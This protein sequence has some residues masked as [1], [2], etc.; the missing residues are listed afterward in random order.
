ML[1]QGELTFSA[2]GSAPCVV[3][4]H[5]FGG[6]AAELRPLLDRIASA[7]YAV[8]AALLPGHGTDPADLQ[9]VRW[10]DWVGAARDRARAAAGRYGRFFLLGFSLGSLVA[11]HLA[12]EAPS[13]GLAGLVALGTAVRLER[14]TQLGLR[15]FARLGHRMPDLYVRKPRP[16][17]LVDQSALSS[18]ATYDR[19]PLRAAT[20][21]VAMGS[22]VS[23]EVGRVTCPTLILHGRKDR[24][25][26]WQNAV[27]LADHVGSKD[28]SVRIFERSAHVLACD[29]EREEVAQ[30]VLAFLERLR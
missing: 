13:E 19:N 27:W 2:E 7:G 8:D 20:Q 9:R 24:V 11:L 26:P 21:V 17:D 4:F 12:S 16:G 14:F 6:S 25:C 10:E 23:G 1:G 3:A 30:E 15:A 29:F 18:L 28:V 5:G 22:L